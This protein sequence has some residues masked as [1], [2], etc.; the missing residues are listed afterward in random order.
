MK[1]R[2]VH[3]KI[4]D[5]DW[6]IAL[7][8]QARYF[9]FY[10]I[11][12]SRINLS[13]C[14][15]LP[16]RVMAFETDFKKED[17]VVLKKALSPKVL[18]YENWVY[19]LNASRLGGYKGEKNDVAVKKEIAEAPK[20]IMDCF[21]KGKC[22]RVL[23][24]DDRVLEVCNTSINHKSETINK[25]QEIRNKNKKAEKIEK[26]P[27]DD[28]NYLGNI[29]EA[30]VVYF[31]E[32]F[33]VSRAQ[34]IKKGKEMFDWV[35]SKG[36]QKEYKD[37]KAVLR[38]AVRKDFGEKDEEKRKRDKELQ[39]AVARIKEKDH[40]NTAPEIDP[41]TAKANMAKLDEMRRKHRIGKV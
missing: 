32:D 10:I 36:K 17:L 35:V 8:K 1:T 30:D 6:F 15:E 12:N 27:E 5:D 2:I 23:K 28:F 3:T 9:F 31:T 4:W 41:E 22:D 26:K 37:F 40:P 20:Y 24:N 18:F 11:T 34:L 13:G 7:N 33:E 29:P 21:I 38:N 14:F 19:V 16:D 25:K 39:I